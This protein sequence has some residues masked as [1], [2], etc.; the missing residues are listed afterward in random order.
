VGQPLYPP[1]LS[2]LCENRPLGGRSDAP[3]D[4]QV[5]VGQEPS[6]MDVVP[7]GDL[8]GL[9]P[10]AVHPAGESAAARGGADVEVVHEERPGALVCGARQP[11]Q[12][13]PNR[14]GHRTVIHLGYGV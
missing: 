3:D 7:V 8:G 6:Q 12:R 2:A 5:R 10:H 14:L 4:G 9:V 13:L 11:V 1:Q